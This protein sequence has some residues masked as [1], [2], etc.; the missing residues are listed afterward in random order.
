MNDMHEEI[1]SRIAS[2]KK[3]L[4]SDGKRGIQA[5]FSGMNMRFIDLSSADLSNS[6]LDKANFER[7]SLNGC[8]F[9][10]ASMQGANL[11]FA[12]I[13]GADF[14]GANLTGANLSDTSLAVNFRRAV[15][16]GA[17]L[18][19]AKLP[20]SC[21]AMA[22]LRGAD[23]SN[24]ALEKADFSDAT[25]SSAKF[26][27]ANME[28]A[29][30][31]R[32]VLDGAFLDRAVLRKA[33]FSD[34]HATIASFKSADLTECLIERSMFALAH[35]ENSILSQ[36]EMVDSNFDG[37][38]FLGANFS[39]ASIKNCSF[40]GVDF[41][42]AQTT[43]L[44]LESVSMGG[45]K[46]APKATR[47][48]AFVDA[49]LT[50]KQRGWLFKRRKWAKI[51]AAT[52]SASSDSGP[53]GS[54][55]SPELER[56]LLDLMKTRDELQL[57]QNRRQSMEQKLADEGSVGLQADIDQIR[58]QHRNTCG[59]IRLLEGQIKREY[60]NAHKLQGELRS[61]VAL[62]VDGLQLT[63][64]P[65]N[66]HIK[67]L[68]SWQMSLSGFGSVFFVFAM[69]RIALEL[70]NNEGLHQILGASSA[71]AATA[72]IA[73]SYWL[74]VELLLI[75]AGFLSFW[76]SS[77]VAGPLSY[78]MARKERL[79]N[80][81]GLLTAS[82]HVAFG[83]EAKQANVNRTYEAVHEL[84]LD[85]SVFRQS[86]TLRNSQFEA[87]RELLLDASATSDQP[88]TGVAQERPWQE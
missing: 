24:T 44:D 12:E 17:V 56:Q 40:R 71:P 63:L 8:K 53:V 75:G 14:A 57:S 72:F 15:L 88:G 85:A 65:F 87:V 61:R 39:Q 82:Q 46:E 43:G 3:W 47:N 10:G 25:M 84:L 68:R 26:I 2:H 42:K 37:A 66:Q 73:L 83:I 1:A 51:A 7:A 13:K 18:M 38:T 35:M 5:N 48:S 80:L 62:A 77:R 33:S 11:Q 41:R 9:V 59:Q 76:M 34:A 16:D 55:Y 29:L 36:V 60:D 52:A 23:F 79:H 81:I 70:I 30:L 54:G 22:S 64:A 49:K 58:Y 6:V 31:D 21:F 74:I 27:A 19:R 69:A 4:T 45:A 32:V 78:W 50:A 20:E 67:S 28:R 86:E